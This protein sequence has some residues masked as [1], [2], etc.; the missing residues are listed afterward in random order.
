MNYGIVKPVLIAFF[1]S[2]LLSPM[3]IRYLHKLKFGQ[4][5]RGEGPESHLKK[6]GTPT[7]GGLII[8][9]GIVIASLFYVR[10][11]PMIIPVLF[12]TLGFGF[13]GFIDD[14]IKVVM[15][16]NLGLHAYY[17][18]NYTEI[19]TSM[20]IPFTHGKYLNLGAFFV[21]AVFIILL[22]TVNGANFTDGLD[23][24]ASSVTVLIATYFTVAAL[25]MQQDGMSAGIWPISCATV[26]SLLGFLVF[27]V[28]PARVFMGDT[29]S[30][31]LGG[32]V[33]ATA[34]ILHLPLFI[35][36]VALIYMVE[37]LSVMLQV[38]YF[39]ATKG[40]RLFKM[41]PIHHHFEL[42]G[43]PETKVVAIFAI[44]TAV[45]CLIGLV[46]I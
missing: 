12:V 35:R 11:Y 7:M 29:G 18:I 5:I 16:R 36:I 37:V 22:G 1:V 9:L 19:G 4:F 23:G 43:W 38:G 27:N 21:P 25:G 28:Y 31:A 32:F 26:G 41:A 10:R 17:L 46:A 42:S 3:M 39:K 20:L 6:S 40:K 13:I 8:L 24:L 14:Y 33:A 30:L 34:L 44:T 2:V 45:C 15:K